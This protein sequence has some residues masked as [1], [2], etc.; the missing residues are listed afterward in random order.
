M[1]SIF[2]NEGVLFLSISQ[3]KQA[4]ARAGVCRGGPAL[5]GNV[6]KILFNCLGFLNR[7]FCVT[8]KINY[9]HV[10]VEKRGVLFPYQ[11]LNINN[12]VS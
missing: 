11:T 1:F 8:I 10:S 6:C 5:K 12:L 3:L 7:K 9:Y 4:G 2:Q